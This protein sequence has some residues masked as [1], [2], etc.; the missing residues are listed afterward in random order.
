MVMDELG[1]PEAIRLVD[2]LGDYGGGVERLG[3][4]NEVDTSRR[5]GDPW[6]SPNVNAITISDISE[7]TFHNRFDSLTA[8]ILEPRRRTFLKQATNGLE[9]WKYLP[10]RM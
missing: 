2:Q 1:V 7:S 8:F 3:S 9:L 5:V 10:F 6:F 4:I